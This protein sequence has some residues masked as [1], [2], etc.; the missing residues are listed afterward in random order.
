MERFDEKGKADLHYAAEAMAVIIDALEPTKVSENIFDMTG[1]LRANQRERET[2]WRDGSAFE[3][4]N[5]G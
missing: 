3:E 2:H 4:S 5:H 1:K